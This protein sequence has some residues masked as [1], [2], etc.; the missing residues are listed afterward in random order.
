M[1][2]GCERNRASVRTGKVTVSCHHSEHNI[3]SENLEHESPFNKTKLVVHAPLLDCHSVNGV[4]YRFFI[5]L[6][7]SA[8]TWRGS[9]RHTWWFLGLIFLARLHSTG[10]TWRKQVTRENRPIWNDRFFCFVLFIDWT[11]WTAADW[12]I[13]QIR[14]AL[15]N[16]FN[17]KWG[18][19]SLC[20][21]LAGPLNAWLHN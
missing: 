6:A 16:S 10:R 21:S 4:W 9:G 18:H 14:I 8:G 12:T 13:D 1:F 17:C 15:M 20:C 2:D 7:F 3:Q 19:A 5:T 11:T